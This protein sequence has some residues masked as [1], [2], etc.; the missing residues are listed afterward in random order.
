MNTLGTGNTNC[1]KSSWKNIWKVIKH[2]T[3]KLLNNWQHKGGADD[4]LDWDFSVLYPVQKR[5]HS[6]QTVLGSDSL[7][8]KQ[9]TLPLGCQRAFWIQ[10]FK[11]SYEIQC[12]SLEGELQMILFSC[13]L[14]GV[15]SAFQVPYSTL[16][17][18]CRP[19]I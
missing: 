4:M 13:R 6:V 8:G 1:R 18:I 5:S 10:V 16:W 11:K 9:Q 14:T 3:S 7:K 19:S 17:L 15:L 2:M 12:G